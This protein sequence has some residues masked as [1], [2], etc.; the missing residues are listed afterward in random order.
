VNSA[1]INWKYRGKTPFEVIQVL[2]GPTLKAINFVPFIVKPS[3]AL[4]RILS[5]RSFCVFAV[6]AWGH[7]LSF[8]AIPKTD[9]R[10]HL[11][12]TSKVQI[13]LNQ[14]CP[15]KFMRKTRKL[16]VKLDKL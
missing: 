11:K 6:H 9:K 14:A 10:K 3:L 4:F 16:N 13:K 1:N 8:T 15:C 5:I 12:A 7:D 2:F